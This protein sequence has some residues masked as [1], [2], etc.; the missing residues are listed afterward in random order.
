ME[1]AHTTHSERNGACANEWEGWRGEH[2]TA[3]DVE[4]IGDLRPKIRENQWAQ[5]LKCNVSVWK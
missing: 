4:K 5:D 3:N 1:A 2:A